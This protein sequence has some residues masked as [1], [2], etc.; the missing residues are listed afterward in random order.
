MNSVTYATEVRMIDIASVDVLNPRE[1]NDK[2]FD[3]IVVNI[4]Q[5]GLKKPITVTARQSPDGVERL[6]LVCGEGR[7][8]AFKALGES[9]IP[10]LVIDV[11]DEDAFIMSLAENIARR[12]CRPLELL[13]GIE[14]LREMGYAAKAI[15]SK[16]GLA[17]LAARIRAAFV[18]GSIAKREDTASSEIDLM[19]I[20]DDLAYSDL[21]ATLE[22]ASQ[23]LGRTVNPT[24]YTPQE[25]AKR[26]KGKEAF[27][28]RVLAQPKL[29]LIGAEDALGL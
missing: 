19:L 8:K 7:L 14:Q 29:W 27:A 15:A 1:R 9:R 22:A 6:L 28:T 12:Q 4:K 16:T 20:S 13:A 11:T 25:L 2:V 23:Q 5:V 18:Y 17:P 24:I 3:E 21:Y 26:V 10:A